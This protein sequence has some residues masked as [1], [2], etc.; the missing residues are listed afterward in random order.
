M[1]WQKYS[2]CF[3]LESPLHIGYRKVGNLMQTRG[4]VPGKNLWA[5]LTASLT[6]DAGKGFDRQH[7]VTVGDEVNKYFRF[8]YLYPALPKNATEGIH[9]IDDATIY[10]P[11]ED[12][13]FDYRFFSSYASTALNYEQ[14]AAAEGMLHEAEFMRP[15]ARPLH[16]DEQ[17]LPVYLI[18]DLYVHNNLGPKLTGW[19]SALNQIQIGGERRYGWGRLRLSH[20]FDQ[21]AY[22]DVTI[23]IKKGARSLAHVQIEGVNLIGPVEPMVGWERN[24]EQTSNKL[25][26][27]SSAT[28]CYAPGA[29]ITS[30]NTF[31][32]DQHG[33]WVTA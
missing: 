8:G 9:A 24:P 25:W 17:P 30:E 18:G 14:L 2:L 32:I 20:L 10:Y 28:I 7:Y 26:R 11:W 3:R 19:R 27:L 21:G 29:L 13:L 33:V 12:D 15:W 22:E 5:F 16:D 31:T 6:R 4:Y 23:N 1:S